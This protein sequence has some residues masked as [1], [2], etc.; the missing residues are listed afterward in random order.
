MFLTPKGEPFWGGTYFPP[1]QRFNR[2]GFRDVLVGIRQIWDQSQDKVT[3]NV[4]AIQ[5]ALERWAKPA[6]GGQ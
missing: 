3:K 4:A 6:A 2:P 5:Q 1:Q